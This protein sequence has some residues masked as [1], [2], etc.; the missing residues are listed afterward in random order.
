MAEQDTSAF[1]ASGSAGGPQL[2]QARVPLDRAGD[3]FAQ[4]DASGRLPIVVQ[5]QRLVRVNLPLTVG[6]VVAIVLALVLPIQVVAAGVIGVAGIVALVLGLVPTLFV[7]I[8]EGSQAMLV[9]RGRYLRTLGAGVHV[10]RPGIGVSHLVTSREIPFDA[11]VVGI[12]TSDDVRVDLDILLTFRI[13]QP[14]RFVYAIAPSDFDQVFQGTCQEAIRHLVRRIPI[15]DVLDLAQ[16]E[17]GALGAGIGSALEG[18][19]VSVERALITHVAPPAAFMDSREG[20]RLASIQQLEQAER[21]ALEQRRQADREA[22]ARQEVAARLARERE[23]MERR[24]IE[25]ETRRRVVEVEAET[26]AFRLA[27]LDERLKSHPDA[28]AWDFA[29]DRLAVARALAGN[30]RAMLHVGGAGD[31][32]DALVMRT[33]EGSAGAPPAA[34]P[35]SPGV[36]AVREATDGEQGAG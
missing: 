25:A 36:G 35:G 24:V 20:R 7:S 18:Y 29:R 6:G 8:P 21:F 26:E 19:G 9:R 33:L 15:D 23:E 14:E 11:Q 13:A 32:V 22:L 31:V 1:V 12:A 28:A 3:A 27:R 4:P 17:S 34:G 10:V 2:T 16:T 5:P 30:S